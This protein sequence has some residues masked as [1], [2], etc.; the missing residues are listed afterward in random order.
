[1]ERNGMVK[2]LRRPYSTIG[3]GRRAAPRRRKLNRKFPRI[4][5]KEMSWFC[6]MAGFVIAVSLRFSVSLPSSL[7]HCA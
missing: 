2:T 6:L 7:I 4:D 1:M 3:N 5:E